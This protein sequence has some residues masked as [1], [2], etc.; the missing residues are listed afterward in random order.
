M[1][2]QQRGQSPL[3]PAAYFDIRNCYFYNNS[4][5]AEWVGIWKPFDVFCTIYKNF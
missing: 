5:G 4:K 2:L 3:G 1:R